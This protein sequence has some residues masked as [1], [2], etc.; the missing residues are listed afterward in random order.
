LSGK[1]VPL[2]E[3]IFS[4]GKGV[5]VRV[6]TWSKKTHATRTTI[7]CNRG[8]RLKWYGSEHNIRTPFQ[9]NRVMF[10]TVDIYFFFIYPFF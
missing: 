1:R 7:R 9:N 6:F 3:Y 8:R 4:T 2:N 5:K 10:G